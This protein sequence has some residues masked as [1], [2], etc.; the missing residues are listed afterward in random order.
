[1]VFPELGK[2]GGG[3]NLRHISIFSVVNITSSAGTQL[4]VMRPFFGLC[5]VISVKILGKEKRSK[6][7]KQRL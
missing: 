7:H 6:P 1:M 2:Y 3:L 4:Y 5:Q